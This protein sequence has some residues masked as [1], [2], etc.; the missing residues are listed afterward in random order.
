MHIRNS[1]RNALNHVDPGNKA[2]V[3]AASSKQPTRRTPAKSGAS[4]FAD[5]KDLAKTLGA[6]VPVVYE[7]IIYENF[8]M[9]TA[10]ESSS[11]NGYGT[12]TYRNGAVSG[13]D[14]GRSSCKETFRIKDA[15]FSIMPRLVKE[16]PGHAKMPDGSISLVSLGRGVFCKKVGWYIYVKD[17]SKMSYVQFTLDG[18]MV[19]VTP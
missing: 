19:R 7:L 12:F 1:A 15:D 5:V 14:D 4:L 17:G 10:P 13:P 18:K 6:K 3:V 16:A 11:R 2:T 8:A 9:A